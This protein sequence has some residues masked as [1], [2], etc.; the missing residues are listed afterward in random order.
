MDDEDEEFLVTN[1]DDGEQYRVGEVA[2]KFTVVRLDAKEYKSDAK[3]REGEEEE[4]DEKFFDAKQNY[5]SLN[6]APKQSLPNYNSLSIPEGA[7][8]TFL[9]I[10]AVG[11]TRDADDKAYSVY[12]LDVRCNVASPTS[13]FVYRRYSQFR[14]LSDVLRNEGYYVPVLPPKKLLGTFSTDFVKQRKNDLEAWLYNL[15]DMHVNYPGSKDPQNHPY[16]RK[17]LTEDANKPPQPLVRIYP[18]QA[19]KTHH[20]AEAKSTKSVKVR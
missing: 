10:S 4:E 17:F 9:K 18:E 7:R 15:A 1:L 3:I 2:E 11:T 6:S 20:N 16:Y 12:Y 14:R 8:L 5:L 13:W 19:D